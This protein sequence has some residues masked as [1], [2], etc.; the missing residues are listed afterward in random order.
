MPEVT[1]RDVVTVLATLAGRIDSIGPSNDILSPWGRSPAVLAQ[2]GVT[3]QEASG[4]ATALHVGGT[5]RPDGR[6]ATGRRPRRPGPGRP[7][8][9]RHRPV[10]C[11][12]G[13]GPRSRDGPATGSSAPNG[14]FTKRRRGLSRPRGASLR[15]WSPGNGRC[16]RSGRRGLASVTPRLRSLRPF[17]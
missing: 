6:P 12:G 1:G 10:V 2:T 17:R 13:R 9:G 4:G 5:R 3:L 15:R 16:L 8:R 7:P 11:P 14:G